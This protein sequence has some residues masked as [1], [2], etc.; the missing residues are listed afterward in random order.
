MPAREDGRLSSPLPRLPH[1]IPREEHPQHV[2]DQ[3]C[4]IDRFAIGLRVYGRVAVEVSLEC[5]WTREGQLQH[6]SF[7]L[8]LRQREW[9]L[10][11][12][13]HDLRRQVRA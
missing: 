13:L 3:R 9:S 6:D 7:Q 5:G 4:R 8:R 1:P 11:C 10:C 2:R 12:S